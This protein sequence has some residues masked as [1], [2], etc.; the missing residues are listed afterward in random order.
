[1]GSDTSKIDRHT[2]T[3]VQE[4]KVRLYSKE[5]FMGN[6]YE[7][8]Y[9][10]YTS[11]MFIKMISPDN[12]F[13]LAIPPNTSIVMF[14]GDMYDYGGKGSVHIVN[15]T[16]ERADV[17]MLPMNVQGNVRSLSITKTDNG[18]LNTK[19]NSDASMNDLL[20]NFSG[21][22]DNPEYFT[23]NMTDIRPSVKK[24]RVACI[25]ADPDMKVDDNMFDNCDCKYGW[26]WGFIALL[27]FIIL[28]LLFREYR[29]YRSAVQTNL[30]AVTDV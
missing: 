30:T 1:M 9:G 21:P 28:L 27:I 4:S 19:T 11:S 7:I 18:A 13:S 17:P 26:M 23:E 15:V 2:I 10:N 3:Q 29:T 5:N 6:V 16:N 12:V 20:N 22:D 8:D 14:C 24:S 25:C